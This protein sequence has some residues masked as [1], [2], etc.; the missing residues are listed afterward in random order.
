M[1]VIECVFNYD[2]TTGQVS[3]QIHVL[4]LDDYDKVQFVT[5]TPGLMLK[6]EVN[7]PALGL[8]AGD[9][10]PIR[11]TTAVRETSGVPIL[12]VYYHGTVSQFACGELDNR[13][14]FQPWPRGVGQKS[15]GGGSH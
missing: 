13:N 8:N 4:A 15:V 12:E 11:Y 5:Q 9:L 6:A 10:A 7:L 2:E 14:A 3:Q 1:A